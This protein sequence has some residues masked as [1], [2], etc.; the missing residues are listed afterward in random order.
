MIYKRETRSA[1]RRRAKEDEDGE[2]GRTKLDPI[3][4]AVE[5]RL[6]EREVVRDVLHATG[7]EARSLGSSSR[8]ELREESSVECDLGFLFEIE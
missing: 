7:L 5:V 4:L 8:R 1:K 6:M 2:V 3:F